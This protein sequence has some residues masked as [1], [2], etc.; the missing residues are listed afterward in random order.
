[1]QV[2]PSAAVNLLN[3]SYFF[4]CYFI[5]YVYIVNCNYVL[6]NYVCMFILGIQKDLVA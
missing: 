1:M 3:F 6:Y 4:F 5:I 2:S